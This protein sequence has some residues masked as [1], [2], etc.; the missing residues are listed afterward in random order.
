MNPFPSNLVRGDG[1]LVVDSQ[2]FAQLSAHSYTVVLSFDSPLATSRAEA[3]VSSYLVL[4]LSLRPHR[5]THCRLVLLV[6]PAEVDW[7]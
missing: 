7:P 2:L 5:F 4:V 1:G 6:V 3:R